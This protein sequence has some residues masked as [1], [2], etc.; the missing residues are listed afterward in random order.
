MIWIMSCVR[1]II[2]DTRINLIEY[3]NGSLCS[4]IHLKPHIYLLSNNMIS[5]KK[6]KTGQMPSTFLRSSPISRDSI[7]RRRSH[8][9]WNWIIFY[10]IPS[11]YLI[12]HEGVNTS[13]TLSNKSRLLTMI[14]RIIAP[15]SES[16]PERFVSIHKKRVSSNAQLH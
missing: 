15:M 12:K 8:H 5:S 4:I 1:I 3:Q 16:A 13:S 9:N 7:L 6:F 14:N 2:T 11:A 10:I